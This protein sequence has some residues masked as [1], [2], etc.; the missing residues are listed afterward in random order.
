MCGFM[1]CL[2]P[3]L[4]QVA[5]PPCL[6]RVWTGQIPVLL[7]ASGTGM[8]YIYICGQVYADFLASVVSTQIALV[9]IPQRPMQA[10]AST[11]NSSPL[12]S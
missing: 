12:I 9:P 2:A 1:R 5:V 8:L 4:D 11:L 10:L 6:V 3:G 7:E